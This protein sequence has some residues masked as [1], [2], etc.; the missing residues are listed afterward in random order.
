M[1][2]VFWFFFSKKNTFF[3]CFL[4]DCFAMTG[5]L[6]LELEEELVGFLIIVEQFRKPRPPNHGA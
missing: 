3:A 6:L 5:R 4:L 2:K 1:I